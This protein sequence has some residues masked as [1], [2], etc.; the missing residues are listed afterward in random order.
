[1]HPNK[2]KLLFREL[3][4]CLNMYFDFLKCSQKVTPFS[5][6]NL[7]L[8]EESERLESYF[9]LLILKIKELAM[10]H[11][12]EAF[13][14]K[15]FQD[16]VLEVKL[17][18]KNLD[19]K[20]AKIRLRPEKLAQEHMASR[21]VYIYVLNKQYDRVHIKLSLLQATNYMV[22]SK[23]L[24]QFDGITYVPAE[25]ILHKQFERDILP[26][27]V[28]LAHELELKQSPI[29]K[30]ETVERQHGFLAFLISWS[31]R[32]VAGNFNAMFKSSKA[33]GEEFPAHKYNSYWRKVIDEKGPIE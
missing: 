5:T 3:E 14:P 10:L 12:K 8:L 30:K 28:S 9:D 22:I 26:K 7:D 25:L 16:L 18:Q 13:V 23:P 11:K 20:V 24:W 19:D 31:S 6:Q 29:L 27:K 1:M 33:D 4:E 2:A 21:L 15:Y 17:L 32:M